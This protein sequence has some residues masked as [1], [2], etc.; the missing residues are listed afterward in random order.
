M[1]NILVLL[2]FLPILSF[3]QIKV[4]YKAD[5]GNNFSIVG[6]NEVATILYDS[7]ENILIQ[8]VAEFLASDIEKVSGK[9][10][11]VDC[12]N[13]LLDKSLI[14]IGTV[15]NNPLINKLVAEH[16]LKADELKGQ[17]ERFIIQTIKN[18]FPGV[19]QAI[20]I[21]GSDRRG[22]AYGVFTLSKNMGVSPW[23]WWA[24]VP[25]EKHDEIYLEACNYLSKSPAV[26]Y[27]GIFINDEAPAFRNWAKEK[28][29]GIN[30][31]CYEKVYELLLRN[32]A[33]YLWPAMWLPSMFYVDDPLNAKTADEYGIVISTSHHEPLT[34]AHNE[35]AYNKGGEWNYNTNKKRLQEFWRGGVER[36]ANY[37]T[38]LTVGMRG[39]G[40]EG[41]SEESAV[42]LLQTIIK[43]QR[44]IITSVTGKPANEIPQVW[45]I[46]KEVQD[47]Y[48]KG[49]RVDDDIMVLFSDDNWGN[50]RY[51]PKKE[52]LHRPG[53]YGMYYHFEYVGA[54]VSYKW[55]NVSQIERTWEQ[56]KLTYEHGVKKLWIVNVGD[57]KPMELPMSF[58]LDYAWDPDAIQAH[59]LPDYYINWAKQQF[60][61]KYAKEIAKLISGF[62]QYNARRTPEMLNA[63]TYSIENY[64]E[65]DRV[66]DD[67][68]QLLKES[69]SV[70][71]E[72][73]EHYKSAYYQ[74]VQSPIEL[75]ANLNEMY[76]AAG[77]NR[78]YS[79]RGAASANYY[80][81]KV[82]ELFE[83][84]AVLTK[85]YHAL[86]GGKWNHMMSQTHIGY[87]FWNHP[88]LNTMPAVSYVQLAKTA[89]LG[90]LLE[91]GLT[92]KWGWLGLE[93]EW[94]F[95]KKLPV[96][97]PVNNQNYYIDIINR[98]QDIL[99]Y[100]LKGK[101]DWIILSE[102]SGSTRYNHKVYVS[103][104]WDKIPKEVTSGEIVISG[105]GKSYT[106]VVPVNNNIASMSGF[107]ENNG[108]IAFEA[109]HFTRKYD[110][111]DIHW[112][113]VPNLG[114]TG[115]SLIVEPTTA[116]P[117][118]VGKNTPRVEYEFSTFE[119]GEI[120]IET[121]LSPNQD[122]KKMGGLKYAI[123]IDDEEPQI[124]NVNEGEIIPDYKFGD[125]WQKSVADHIKIRKS[126][127]NMA[128]AGKH[129]LKIWMI[130]SGLVFQ[131]FVIDAG[132]LKKSYLGPDESKKK[133]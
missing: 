74:L 41:L 91:Y 88:P 90:Y 102:E 36:I 33:N 10:L 21:V 100:T 1:K 89:E 133:E 45:A 17:W 37:E 69:S 106:V 130:D 86:E 34:R 28:F 64:R 67:Y 8:K 125:W 63:Q 42:G 4:N 62:T 80:A 57:I 43:D 65:A 30:H 121:Y 124:I 94:S 118:T 38:V 83:K 99:S 96:F 16:K 73:P 78:Y 71:K 132:G 54:P 22:A 19:K 55:L 6:K 129:I 115:S 84:D 131:K 50:L 112:T 13:D 5:T 117:Q 114:R 81:D 108:V 26:Q 53:G 23:Y 15:N 103:I 52:D 119:A 20:V 27:R 77:K 49:M 93:G 70:Y 128:T 48:D 32:K 123:A 9:V 66:V 113:V 56:M 18:P 46:Y 126:K 75:C 25:V 104:D 12:S 11:K 31:T 101:E 110:S 116:E 51:L 3:S 85:K 92:P 14:I 107:I 2:V 60:G 58:F 97:D 82:K 76:V 40:D 109:T 44:E 61:S 127:H 98:G 39:D 122:F 105:A 95:N 120:T 24:D 7:S 47:Y 111:K 68:N 29:G 72:L 87:T 79:L 35:W 59:N